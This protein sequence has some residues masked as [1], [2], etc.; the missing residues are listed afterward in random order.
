MLDSQMPVNS[1]RD[2]CETVEQ[3]IIDS[4]K[5]EIAELKAEIA[6]YEDDPSLL[7]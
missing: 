4:L 6:A 7:V 2:Q 1:S 3:S 5:R